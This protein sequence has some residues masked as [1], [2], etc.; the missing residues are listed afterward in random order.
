VIELKLTL[1]KGIYVLYDAKFR[2]LQKL[3]TSS[4]TLAKDAAARYLIFPCGL[5]RGALANLGVPCEVVA[6]VTTL[7]GCKFQVSIS[8]YCVGHFTIKIKG[9]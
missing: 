3:S 9:A 1:H 5:I 2:W 8:T 7:P 6:E 4:S